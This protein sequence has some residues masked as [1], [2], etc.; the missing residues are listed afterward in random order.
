[1][2]S[3]RVSSGPESSGSTVAVSASSASRKRTA[4]SA[5]RPSADD[6]ETRRS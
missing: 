6:A 5:A 3:T 2:G 4:P 1:G